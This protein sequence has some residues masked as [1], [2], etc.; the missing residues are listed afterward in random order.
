MTTGASGCFPAPTGPGVIY[1]EREIDDAPLRLHDGGLPL[2]LPRRGLGPDWR[3][4]PDRL[5]IFNG[6]LLHRSLPN[7]APGSLRRAVAN[8]YMS[9][10]SLLPW[11]PPR[12]R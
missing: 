7:T 10:Q 6:Y 1:P 8:H 4:P 12:R 11:R 3:W 2:P 5:I 9:A